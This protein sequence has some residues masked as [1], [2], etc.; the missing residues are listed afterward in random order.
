MMSIT[1][2]RISSTPSNIGLTISALL[3]RILL[4]SK[5]LVFFSFWLYSLVDFI[6]FPQIFHTMLLLP[7]FPLRFPFFL[8]LL[9]LL[10]YVCFLFAHLFLLSK[11]GF[12]LQQTV[13][14]CFST[15]YRH[16]IYRI[17]YDSHRNHWAL[18]KS[19]QIIY[20]MIKCQK[21]MTQCSIEIK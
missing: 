14:P 11:L 13:A 5:S 19:K 15:S 9:W 12:L 16:S 20:Q 2:H 3:N 8:L 6:L 7:A 21:I 17:I 18:F 10:L 1:L 4:T